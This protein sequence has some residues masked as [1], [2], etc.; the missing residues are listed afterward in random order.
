M[1]SSFAAPHFGRASLPLVCE[2]RSTSQTAAPLPSTASQ[3]SEVP[4]FCFAASDCPLIHVAYRR[5]E[6]IGIE[7][8]DR[9]QAFTPHLTTRTG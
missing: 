4:S 3:A 6:Q 8:G 2:P 1:N 7:Q 9:A 5:S